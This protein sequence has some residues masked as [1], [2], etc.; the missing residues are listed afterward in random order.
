MLDDVVGLPCKELHLEK[1]ELRV[2]RI[3]FVNDRPQTLNF[4]LCELT[5]DRTSQK[6]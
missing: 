1:P 6:N 3:E 4:L 5:Q 2:D